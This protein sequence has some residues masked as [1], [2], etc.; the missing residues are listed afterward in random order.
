MQTGVLLLFA[1][2][3][4]HEDVAIVSAGFL[5]AERQLPFGALYAVVYTGVMLNNGAMYALGATARR[6]PRLRRWLIGKNVDAL[7]RHLDRGLLPALVLCRFVPGILTPTLLGCGWLGVSFLRFLA[8]AAFAAAAYLAL[9]LTLVIAL[10]E[11]VLRD[12]L[13]LLLPVAVGAIAVV[14]W[15]HRRSRR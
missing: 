7:H 10:G 9:A 11:A 3:L 6:A 1:A 15:K 8:A 2:A 5:A 4:L 13:W 14:V 12:N